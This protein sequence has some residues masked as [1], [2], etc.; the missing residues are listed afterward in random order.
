VVVCAEG[1]L[2]YLDLLGRNPDHM[3]FHTSV[4]DNL[5]VAIQGLVD[6]KEPCSSS[7]GLDQYLGQI[8]LAG[9]FDLKS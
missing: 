1:E 9:L 5:E 4:R 8:L 7:L 2:G 6:Y 3:D